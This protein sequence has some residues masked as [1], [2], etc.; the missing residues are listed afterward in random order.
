MFVEINKALS[1]HLPLVPVTIGESKKQG[2]LDRASGF[3]LHQFIWVTSGEGLFSAGGNTKILTKGQGFFS[4][5]NVPHLY[6][7]TGGKFSTMWVTFLNGENL[8][9][10]YAI[11]DYFFF[12]AP[13]FLNN[14]TLQLMDL[15]KNS[16]SGAIRSAHAFVWTVELLD[17]LFK[18]PVSQAEQIAQFLEY[19]FDKPLTLQEIADYM[20]MDKFQL[21]RR[22]VKET[23]KTVM[24]SLKRLRIQKAK[25]LLRYSAYSVEQI[26]MMCGFESAS[27]FIKTFREETGG[28]PRQYRQTK[29]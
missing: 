27:Y 29:R 28:T 20:G 2:R 25:N 26:G 24:Q 1:P 9:D 11:G 12:R 8:L 21:C 19:N 22:Y 16:F 15:C 18:K 7:S 23:G 13:D 5:K 4:R 6:Q 17:A 3:E 14:S 10:Y